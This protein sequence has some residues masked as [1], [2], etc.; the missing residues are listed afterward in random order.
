MSRSG[1]ADSTGRPQK[2]GVSAQPPPA[3]ASAAASAQPPPHAATPARD[4]PYER[5]ALALHLISLAAGLVALVVLS[6]NQWFVS[7]EWDFLADRPLS[8][9]RALFIPHNEHWST[10][11]IVV[12]RLLYATVGLHS[13]LPYLVVGFLVHLGSAHLLWNLQR[14]AGADA[15]IATATSGAFV[16]FGAGGEN[17]LTA[18]GLTFD[19]SVLAGLGQILLVDHAGGFGRRDAGGFVLA[20]AGL[21]SSGIAITMVAVAGFTALLRRGW[22]AA[23]VTVGPPAV[24][25]VIWLA[26]I[27]H[28]GL[29]AHRGSID[30]ANIPPFV[31]RG[32]TN[33]V[34]ISLGLSGAG[35]IVVAGLLVWCVRHRGELRQRAAAVTACAAGSA[36]FFAVAGFGRAGM[37]AQQAESSRY[38]YVAG[39]LLIPMVGVALSD[40]ARRPR[41]ARAV[42]LVLVAVVAANGW[43]LLTYRARVEADLEQQLRRIILAASRLDLSP[44]ELLTLVPEPRF[45]PNLGYPELL[46]MRSEGR[47]PDGDD[48]TRADE[49][50]ALT[51]LQTSF[52]PEPRL[53]SPKRGAGPMLTVA[54]GVHTAPA[55]S[56]CLRAE[57]VAPPAQLLLVVPAP[58]SVSVEGP[59]DALT[60]FLRDDDGTTAG[61]GRVTTLADVPVHL[62]LNVTA[63]TV[64]VGLSAGGPTTICGVE[65]ELSKSAQSSSR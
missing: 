56:G 31:W 52:T 64:V 21:L 45:S 8:D 36:A 39:A 37:H 7:D 25:Y 26:I 47:L 65:P 6:R 57:A 17:L 41:L 34:D 46:R 54:A 49:L 15:W 32:V 11:P 24:I 59:E 35:V 22:R 55:G 48:A 1:A 4:G 12:Y 23:L 50:S 20:L 60:V 43:R 16:V 29:G 13:Y 51:Y 5:A 9:L 44:S 42:A 62:N 40:L 18:F 19:T 3:A 2:S 28:L 61:V 14:R 33:T 27:G 30:V 38:L 10:L 58:A 63:R 53:P